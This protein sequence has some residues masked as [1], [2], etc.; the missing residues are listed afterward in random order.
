MDVVAEQAPATS[1]RAGTNLVWMGGTTPDGD[2][3]TTM[4]G[5]LAKETPPPADAAGQMPRTTPA[6]APPTVAAAKTPSARVRAGPSAEKVR[7][8]GTPCP[9][10]TN[11]RSRPC[12]PGRGSR[13]AR[14]GAS[15]AP[16]KVRPKAVRPMR[17]PADGQTVTGAAAKEQEVSRRPPVAGEIH[18]RPAVRSQTSHA[19]IVRSASCPR[20]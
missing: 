7:D 19:L 3:G 15:P 20:C 12:I 1:S 16:A 5:G 18:C 11:E 17:T 14:S 10:A 8:D 9:G 4:M 6:L 13:P 2:D